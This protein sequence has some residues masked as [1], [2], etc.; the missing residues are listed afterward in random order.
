MLKHLSRTAVTVNYLNVSHSNGQCATGRLF[1]FIGNVHDI[2]SFYGGASSLELSQLLF[3]THWGHLS[4]IFL[5]L[6]GTLF[7][8]GWTG[9]YSYWKV[10]PI[11]TIAISHAIWDPH[12][13]AVATTSSTE[14]L[15]NS[16]PSYSGV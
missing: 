6:S 4:V 16:T 1:D 2:E 5:W 3:S 12:F 15:F 10:N 8:I 13:S 11:S 7:H 14:Y 9:N